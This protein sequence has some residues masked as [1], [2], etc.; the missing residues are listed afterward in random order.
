MAQKHNLPLLGIQPGASRATTI[1]TLNKH[2]SG[3][4]LNEEAVEAM[5]QRVETAFQGK[6]VPRD[7]MPDLRRSVDMLNTLGLYRG[8]VH[9]LSA[10]PPPSTRAALAP[11]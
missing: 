9:E 3:S 5:L 6:S 10:N 11:A 2:L 8:V 1:D 4:Q 7:L